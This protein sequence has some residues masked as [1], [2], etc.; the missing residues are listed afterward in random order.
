MDDDL[1]SRVIECVTEVHREAG[2]G[3]TKELYGDLLALELTAAGLPFER[4]RVLR[5]VYDGHQLDFTMAAEFIV[6]DALVLQ[7]EV[8]DEIELIHE[9]QLRTCVWMGGFALGLLLN[10]N[11]ADI[12]DG[13]SRI[14]TNAGAGQSEY[15]DVFDD[16]DLG[17]EF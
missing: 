11:V 16:P 2:L 13:I 17:A 7:I 15:R 6:A 1:I 12:E 5:M 3:L 8:V 14:T 4:G 10:F 9:Q